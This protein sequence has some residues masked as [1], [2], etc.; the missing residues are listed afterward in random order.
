[1]IPSDKTE[2]IFL[3]AIPSEKKINGVT[4]TAIHGTVLRDLISLIQYSVVQYISHNPGK[5]RVKWV[6]LEQI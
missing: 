2:E 5:G 3:Y 6:I 1:M 4:D